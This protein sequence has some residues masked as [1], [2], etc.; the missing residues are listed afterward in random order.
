MNQNCIKQLILCEG[1]RLQLCADS[2]YEHQ[3]LNTGGLQ[4]YMYTDIIMENC[5]EIMHSDTPGI[6]GI[7]SQLEEDL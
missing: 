2:S 1:V 6:L 5:D 3:Q 7:C 4:R